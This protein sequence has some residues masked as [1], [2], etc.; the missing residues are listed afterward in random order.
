MTRDDLID[1][2]YEAISNAQDM[3]TTLTDFARA[4]V[5]ALLPFMKT[6]DE[7]IK[8]AQDAA[9]LLA[10]HKGYAGDVSLVINFSHIDPFAFRFGFDSK[11][12]DLWVRGKTFAEAVEKL[13]AATADLPQQW[14]N[15]QVAAT[16]GIAASPAPRS[17]APQMSEKLMKKLEAEHWAD[18]AGWC[19]ACGRLWASRGQ[20][21]LTINEGDNPEC[22]QLP[23]YGT[24]ADIIAAMRARTDSK[25]L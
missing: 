23:I 24:P 7:P 18:R 25:G 21:F 14:T 4:A 9:I 10:K 12:S 11:R 5:D 15:E 13:N 6:V 20:T 22:I 16:L 1:V 3:D 17:G 2:A 19:P 8:Y